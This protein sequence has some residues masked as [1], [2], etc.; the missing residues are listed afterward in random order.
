[1]TE[2]PEYL[3]ER[4]RQRRAALGLPGGAAPSGDGGAAPAPAPSG[5]GGAPAAVATAAPPAAAPQPAA[6][7]TATA[8]VTEEPV[9]TVEVESAPR[10]G[11]PNWMMPVLLILPF[12]AMVY[13]GAFAEPAAEGGPR[14][15]AQIYASA[16]CGSCHGPTG[17]GGVGPRLSGGE[18]VLTFPN[19]DDMIRWVTEGSSSVRGQPYGDP[20]RPGGQRGPASGGMPGFGTQLPPEE[21]ATVVDYVRDQL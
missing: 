6:A 20:N 5:D 10:S 4:S 17:G 8:V 11:I 7:A 12:W 3:L 21:I 2:V 9:A 19:R 15:G 14:T 16:G 18:S 1:M 13:M